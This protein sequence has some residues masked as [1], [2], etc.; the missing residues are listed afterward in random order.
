[1]ANIAK[2]PDLIEP[3]TPFPSS[4]LWNGD[5]ASSLRGAAML[6]MRRM[7]GRG[8]KR[9]A[10]MEARLQAVEFTLL[11]ALPVLPP[12]SR[13]IIRKKWSSLP[14]EPSARSHRRPLY[15]RNTLNFIATC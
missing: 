8:K 15:R 11:A 2:L 13:E 10:T 3:W 4:K 12:E 7:F 6:E 5:G 9:E 1:M 14:S